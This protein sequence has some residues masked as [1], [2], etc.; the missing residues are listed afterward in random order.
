L[1]ERLG[2]ERNNLGAGRVVRVGTVGRGK[3]RKLSGRGNLKK[4]RGG[5]LREGI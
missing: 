4:W 1:G 3:G 5:V 2:R